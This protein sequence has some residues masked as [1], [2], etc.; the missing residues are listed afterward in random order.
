MHP[1]RRLQELAQRLDDVFA[2]LGSTVQASIHRRHLELARLSARL[3]A[4]SPGQRLLYLRGELAQC[5]LRLEQAI[6]NRLQR[7]A[8]RLH[9][10]LRALHA[11]SPLATL[12]RGYAIVTDSQA[13]ILRD[14]TA[15][16][17]GDRVAARLA[18]GRLRCTVEGIDIEERSADT[19][20]GR[21]G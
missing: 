11:V 4:L 18:R 2:R 7:E 17:I 1:G 19:I 14:A 10:V 16:R 3:S 8:A 12:E 5:R 21:D 20:P 6:R 9:P 15:A 13:R